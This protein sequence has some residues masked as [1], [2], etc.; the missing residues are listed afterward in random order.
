MNCA[1]NIIQVLNVENVSTA[2]QVTLSWRKGFDKVTLDHRIN[3]VLQNASNTYVLLLLS[4]RNMNAFLLLGCFLLAV[5]EYVLSSAHMVPDEGLSTNRV[6]VYNAM[7]QSLDR[8][9][10]S[11][12]I[13]GTLAKLYSR[14]LLYCLE[15]WDFCHQFLSIIRISFVFRSLPEMPKSVKKSKKAKKTK[16]VIQYKFMMLKCFIV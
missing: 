16:K 3:V 14:F 5:T 12:L 8:D 13:E 9:P 1:N 7:S 4:Y 2:L 6:V 15:R 10:P 11:V